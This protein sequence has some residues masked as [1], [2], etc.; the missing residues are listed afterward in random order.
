MPTCARQR[1]TAFIRSPSRG[2]RAR[3]AMM[4]RP[5]TITPGMRVSALAMP[6]SAA[7]HG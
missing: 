1:S 6:H 5:E 2:M 4:N 7:P 3:N